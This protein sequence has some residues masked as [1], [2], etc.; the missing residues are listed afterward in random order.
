MPN[1]ENMDGI[2]DLSAPKPNLELKKQQW[3]AMA[4]RVDKVRD[5]MDHPIDPGIKEAVIVLNLLGFK[6]TMSCEGHAD[7]PL[8]MPYPWVE[9]QFKKNAREEELELLHQQEDKIVSENKTATTESLDEMLKETTKKRHLLHAE[10]NADYA[11]QARPIYNLLAKF[12]EQRRPMYASVLH[13][14]LRRH[15]GRLQSLTGRLEEQSA[16][17][18]KAEYLAT[19]QAEM[20]AFTEFLKQKFFEE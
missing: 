9:I 11:N 18:R 16:P 14:E 8:A 6:T 1:I 10:I 7:R 15:S 13:F 19:Q 17:G 3:D 20:Q 12:H 5:G 4:A 2:G